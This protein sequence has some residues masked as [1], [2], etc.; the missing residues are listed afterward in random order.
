MLML[1]MSTHRMLI[2]C[3][4]LGLV[5]EDETQRMTHEHERAIERTKSECEREKHRLQKQHSADLEDNIEKTNLKLKNIGKLKLRTIV[6]RY[7]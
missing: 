2:M 4:Y 5:K 3:M 6:T 1:I 7:I